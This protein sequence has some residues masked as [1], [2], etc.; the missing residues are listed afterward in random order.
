MRYLPA[1]PATPTP[2]PVFTDPTG[3]RA[4]VIRRLSWALCAIFAAVVGTVGV[5]LMA[6]VPLPG[7]GGL[8][9]RLDDHAASPVTPAEVQVS[10]DPGSAALRN[11]GPSARGAVDPTPLI[12]SPPHVR[13]AQVRLRYVRVQHRHAAESRAVSAAPPRKAEP[14]ASPAHSGSPR[15]AAS[16]T[17]AAKSSSPQASVKPRNPQAAAK[18][19]S[20]RAVPEPKAHSAS[21]HRAAAAPVAATA[22]GR[23]K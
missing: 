22:P 10:T 2:T 14:A 7:L 11:L 20:P 17:T 15:G 16:P 1:Q 9:P 8:L 18:K 6:Q 21:G 12:L 4:E 13:P 23:N 3:R 5:T 19:P